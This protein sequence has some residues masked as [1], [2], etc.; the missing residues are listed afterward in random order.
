MGRFGFEALG[1]FAVRFLGR[2]RELHH[3]LLLLCLVEL[4]WQGR[5]RG[6]TS[7]GSMD[8]PRF[9]AQM[10]HRLALRHARRARSLRPGVTIG[11]QAAILLSPASGSAGKTRWSACSN[12]MRSF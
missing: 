10:V 5:D 1:F 8:R 7:V 2:R 6:T 9:M 4:Q 12:S 3:V 11:V